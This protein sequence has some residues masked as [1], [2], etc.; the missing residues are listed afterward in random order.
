MKKLLLLLSA[1]L[2]VELPVAGQVVITSFNTNGVLTWT[3]T[4]S[5][6]TYRVEW[7]GSPTG[8]WQ[9]FD[10]LTNLSLLSATSNS[11]T[12]KVPTFYRVVWLDP[13]P[14]QPDGTWEYQAYDDQG[15][16]VVTGRL[17]MVS[18]TN[19]ITGTWDLQLTGNSTNYPGPQI[20]TGELL[21][22]YATGYILYLSLG[23]HR[24][25]HR[26][27]P[28]QNKVSKSPIPSTPGLVDGSS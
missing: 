27:M 28:A 12:V 18:E 4:V 26:I 9:T 11:V 17:F 13:P 25:L 1:F 10:A 3:N 23:V 21:G 5:N 7:A 8:P 24:E 16:L 19:R 14:P 6:A 20:G 22:A 2:S 15:V